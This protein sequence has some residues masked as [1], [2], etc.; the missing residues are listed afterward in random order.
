MKSTGDIKRRFYGVVWERVAIRHGTQTDTIS[1]GSLFLATC[2]RGG[3]A[4]YFE[5]LLPILGIMTMTFITHLCYSGCTEGRAKKK[6]HSWVHLPRV[7]LNLLLASS[8]SFLA[9]RKDGQKILQSGS[10]GFPQDTSLDGCWEAFTP[11]WVYWQISLSFGSGQERL[12]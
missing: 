11:L 10:Y 9:A 12:A 8:D 5:A 7:L 3:D 4:K 1:D 2:F 6:M